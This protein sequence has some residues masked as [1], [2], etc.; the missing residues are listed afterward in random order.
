MSDETGRKDTHA[1]KN[2]I[3]CFTVVHSLVWVTCIVILNNLFG[4]VAISSKTMF[5]HI[6]F[7][8]AS[9]ICAAYADMNYRQGSIIAVS[10]NMTNY[11]SIQQV[12]TSNGEIM[13]TAELTFAFSMPY[14]QMSTDVVRNDI[15][16]SAFPDG[17]T[18]PNLYVFNDMKLT[19]S[20][21]NNNFTFWDIQVS[22]KQNALFGVLVTE[23]QNGGM[24][25]RTL[26]YYKMDND[27]NML[28]PT[29][30]YTLPYMWYVNA[31]S[32]DYTSNMYYAL[33]NMFPGH[34]M[35]T[36]EQQLVLSDMTNMD[37]NPIYPN[38]KTFL[39]NISS[40]TIMF[41]FVSYSMSTKQLFYAG[42]LKDMSGVSGISV[43]VLDLSSDTNN[44][45]S[46][47][48]Y[49]N[50]GVTKVGPLVAQD[51]DNKLYVY[52][53]LN[54]SGK[55]DLTDPWQLIAISYAMN[56]PVEIIA[57][58]TN[59]EYLAIGAASRY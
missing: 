4:I 33:I 14:V 34:E 2:R 27:A 7:L 21:D 38:P 30:L 20:Y 17:N 59:D 9:W 6:T 3:F 5:S 1:K 22:P 25:G 13:D 19:A 12:D 43:G 37:T 55:D 42:P 16:L 11:A 44:P 29:Q 10:Q 52:I 46:K 32:F 47:E 40:E 26:S 41:Q 50:T 23:D 31:S 8:A 18:T 57:T 45:V 36:D 15:Y 54:K 49:S 39:K 48:L 24:Y 53:Q 58:Y 56:N 35:S 28:I 51:K